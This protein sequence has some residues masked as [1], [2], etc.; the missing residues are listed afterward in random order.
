MKSTDEA[1]MAMTEARERISPTKAQ[2][3]LN[4]NTGNRKLR[5]GLVEKYAA[6][7]RSG[8]WTACLAPVAF[9]V[10]GDIADGQHRLWAII[11]SGTTQ[12]FLVVRGFPREAGLNVDTGKI[13]TVVDNARISGQ[14]P[15]LSNELVALARMV[16]EGDRQN[17]PYSNAQRLEFVDMHR[18]AA[19]WAVT[20]GPRGK[21]LRSAATLAA[22][23]RAWYHEDDKD[24]LARFCQ[25]V[26]TGFADGDSES[27]AVALRNYLL[28]RCV[29][30]SG[31]IH[32][33][34]RD[35]FLKTMNATHYFMSG[36]KL[37]VIKGVADEV[38]PL[39]R[40]NAPGA[41]KAA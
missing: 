13:R 9:Y 37:T 3:Y 32:G 28:A 38:Y 27:S 2:M 1:C 31:R 12:E 6:D 35:M 36:R 21:G 39:P 30:R 40:R 29:G 22:I 26:S 5:D 17:K 23:A 4:R 34:L 14:D 11:E 20:H 15:D 25:V 7:M 33:S 18:E 10:N 24:R 41:R 19:K 8:K 16:E